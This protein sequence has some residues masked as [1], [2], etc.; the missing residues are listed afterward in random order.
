[1]NYWNYW[2]CDI[3][4]LASTLPKGC[5]ERL[6]FQLWFVSPPDASLVTLESL[7]VNIKESF[8]QP[9][10]ISYGLHTE[11]GLFSSPRV[12]LWRHWS[13]AEAIP[14]PKVLIHSLWLSCVCACLPAPPRWPAPQQAGNFIQLSAHTCLGNPNTRVL[15]SCK[16]QVCNKCS[17]NKRR[18][19]LQVI[20][21]IITWLV[22]WFWKERITKIF[23]EWQHQGKI[24]QDSKGLA[25]KPTHIRKPKTCSV[26]GTERFHCYSVTSYYE[27]L[28]CYLYI[29]SIN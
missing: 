16:Q 14:F 19:G 25:L 2:V 27:I 21:L 12:L 24:V 28:E 29:L 15:S 22:N 8:Y 11:E 1:M 3:F 9:Q 6:N 26:G 5:F 13:S 18:Y 10:N 23:R 7:W 4:V 17:L 20:V